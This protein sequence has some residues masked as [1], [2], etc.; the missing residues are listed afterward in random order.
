M[1]VKMD[2]KE[3]EWEGM[4]WINLAQDRSGGLLWAR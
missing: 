2:L 4:N 3:M 1:D